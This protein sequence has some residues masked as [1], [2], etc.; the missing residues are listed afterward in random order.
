MSDLPK[1]SIIT[2]SYNQANFIEDAIKSVLGQNYPNF[3]HIIIDGGSVDGT[4]DILKKYPHLKWISEPD[5]GQSEAVNKGIL[6]S[7]GEIIGW[8]NADDIYYPDT[9]RAVAEIFRNNPNIDIIFG[10][11]CYIDENGELLSI[12]REIPF[13]FKIYLWTKNCY[14]ANCAGFFKRRCFEQFGLLNETLH[15]S[16]DFELYLRFY[17]NGCQFYQC[18]KIFGGYRIHSTSKTSLYKNKQREEAEKIFELYKHRIGKYKIIG[19][20]LP[21]F[22]RTYRIILKVFKGYYNQNIPILLKYFK[23]LSKIK[24]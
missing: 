17:I 22:Y 5:K 11:Y 4:V 9:F 1:I 24:K 12:R 8:L 14:H 10:N 13:N 16:M 6:I 20:I 18:D 2:P 21:L 7:T 19:F 15:Y 3:E 23:F